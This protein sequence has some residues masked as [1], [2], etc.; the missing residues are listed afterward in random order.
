MQPNNTRP[1]ATNCHFAKTI[2][3]SVWLSVLWLILFSSPPVGTRVVLVLPQVFGVQL[4]QHA[5]E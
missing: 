3:F 4:R 2:R 5:G 1:L